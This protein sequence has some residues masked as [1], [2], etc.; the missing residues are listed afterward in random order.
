MLYSITLNLALVVFILGT[1]YRVIRWFTV[2]VGPDAGQFTVPARASRAIKGLFS[3]VFS[4]HIF[5][6]IRTFFFQ[7]IFQSHILKK[8]P[9]RWLMHLNIFAGILL[10]VLFHALDGQITASL[11]LMSV[12]IFQ[13][14][15]L[16]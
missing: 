16:K 3:V 7:V 11:L 9:W 15:A 13:H 6:L 10:L 14:Q 5:R 2:R 1:I 4:R 12:T 8:D